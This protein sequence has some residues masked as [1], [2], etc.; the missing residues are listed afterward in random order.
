MDVYLDH[1]SEW[2]MILDKIKEYFIGK[3]LI[4]TPYIPKSC[5]LGEM[6]VIDLC[7]HDDIKGIAEVRF[8]IF[9]K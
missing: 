6:S 7:I 2:W 4:C 5:V 9:F 3:R 8:S 1:F